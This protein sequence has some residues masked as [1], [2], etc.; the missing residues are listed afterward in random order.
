MI[1]LLLPVV[2][3]SHAILGH[4]VGVARNRSNVH[5]MAIHQD[6]TVAMQVPF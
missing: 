3:K 5:T 6:E 1:R 2:V 4:D